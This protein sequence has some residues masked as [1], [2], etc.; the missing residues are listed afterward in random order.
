VLFHAAPHGPFSGGF[1]GV[2]LFFVLSAFLISSTLTDHPELPRFY[3]H[4]FCRLAP[5]LLAML[6]VYLAVAPFIWPGHPHGVDALLAAG[7]VADYSYPLLGAPLYLQHSWSLAVE[8]QFYLVWPF[9]L[10]ALRRV[11]HPV[12][13]LAAVFVLLTAWRCAWAWP[14]DYYRFDTHATGL[15][16]GAMLFFARPK[17]PRPLGYVA[18]GALVLIAC[19]ANILHSALV[20]TFAELCAV[21][22][23]AAPPPFL[24]RFAWLG[25]RSYA[26][27][28]WHFPIAYAVREH[29]GFLPTAAITLALSI[30]LASL[31]YATVERW[32]RRLRDWPATRRRQFS[33]RIPSP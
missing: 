15:I 18:L 24:A 2:D 22:V 12:V 19:T 23:I 11:R 20:I 21:L 8:E 26:V 16:A 30:G 33:M 17:V 32:G 14:H 7:Y 6:V 4:R 31:S 5:A 27:Y 29:F 9:A 3:W 13:L 1:V 25:R 28:L 10:I